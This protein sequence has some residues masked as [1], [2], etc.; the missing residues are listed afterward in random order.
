MREYYV[1]I[2]ASR[3][4]GTLYTG[5]TSTLLQ[6]VSQHKLDVVPGFTKRYGVHRLRMG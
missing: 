6:R 5:V 3:R 1:Y 2:L 4:D